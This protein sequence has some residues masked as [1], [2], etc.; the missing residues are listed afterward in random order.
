MLV[1]YARVSTQD[2]KRELQRDALKEAKC[3][4]VFEDKMNGA[5]A[6]R[7]GLTEALAFMRPGDTLVIWKLSRLGRSMKQLIETV[8]AMQDRGVVLKS[9]NESIDTRTP[10]GKLLFHIVAAF[11]PFE[12]EII[13]ERV[14][15][16]IS[17][18]KARGKVMGRSRTVAK[19]V[20]EI[21]AL[22]QAGVSQ[23]KIAR[24]LAVG[25]TSVRRLLAPV[26][27]KASGQ[28]SGQA[29]SHTTLPKCYYLKQ[30]LQ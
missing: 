3:E 4:R 25:R 21:Y 7:P 29:S 18:A 13:R 16:G 30:Q 22:Y 14:K 1:G 27:T 12:R 9:L 23:A 15:A 8:Q 20:E 5:K 24:R 6:A 2:Q 10:T 19:Q 11:A 17:Q 26:R 28:A